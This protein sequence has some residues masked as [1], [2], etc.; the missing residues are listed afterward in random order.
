MVTK[1]FNCVFMPMPAMAATRH[2]REKSPGGTWA[3]SQSWRER[4]VRWVN[5]CTPTW[6]NG[7]MTL[8][9]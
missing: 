8:L 2:H 3:Q 9:T 1:A 7:V 4:F 5:L 6:R